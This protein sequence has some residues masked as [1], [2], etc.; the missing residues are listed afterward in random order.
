MALDKREKSQ[1]HSLVFSLMGEI[2]KAGNID[3]KDKE[4][5]INQLR[6]VEQELYK[7]KPN[8]LMIKN[9]LDDF[10]KSLPWLKFKLQGLK[11]HPYVREILGTMKQ[12]DKWWKRFF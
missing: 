1:I 12:K 8:P 7:E 4:Y 5:F 2:N 11:G 6:F 3:A 10:N 9:S